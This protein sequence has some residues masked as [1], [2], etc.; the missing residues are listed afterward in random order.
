LSRAVV[1]DIVRSLL[2]QWR[3]RFGEL[4]PIDVEQIIVVTTT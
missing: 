1:A 4:A 3:D 2:G